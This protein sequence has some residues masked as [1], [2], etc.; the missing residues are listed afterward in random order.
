M[1]EVDLGFSQGS[2][3]IKTKQVDPVANPR[4]EVKG[5]VGQRTRVGQSSLVEVGKLDENSSS[6]RHVIN[7]RKSIWVSVVI[8]Q[9]VT[10]V[11]RLVTLPEAVRT[12]ITTTSPTI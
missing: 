9:D 2:P 5:I 1:V 11:G 12:A 3:T 10:I 7:V 8:H 4:L 6:G